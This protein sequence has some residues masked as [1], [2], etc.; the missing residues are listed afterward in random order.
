MVIHILHELE[1]RS[2]R[3]RRCVTAS[4][5][6]SCVTWQRRVNRPT[7]RFDQA[8]TENSRCWR[9]WR[10]A[11]RWP[12]AGRRTRRSRRRKTAATVK[13]RR[14]S[15]SVWRCWTSTTTTQYRQVGEQPAPAATGLSSQRRASACTYNGPSTTP[16]AAHRRRRRRARPSVRRRR[17]SSRGGPTRHRSASTRARRS[18]TEATADAGVAEGCTLCRRYES[19]WH[20]DAAEML[21]GTAWLAPDDDES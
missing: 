1:K 2:S 8:S 17:T 14:S 16:A 10:R 5:C 11:V 13:R 4:T 3:L 12:A 21:I 9:R 20:R 7:W 6:R 19:G 15:A 18:W